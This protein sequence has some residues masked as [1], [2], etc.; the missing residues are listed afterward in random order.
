MAS[1]THNPE[2]PDQVV[3]LE[4]LLRLDPNRPFANTQDAVE[5][6]IPFYVR[7]TLPSTSNT[8]ESVLNERIV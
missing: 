5:R 7:R 6:L 1:H 4:E 3:G 2:N 8:G